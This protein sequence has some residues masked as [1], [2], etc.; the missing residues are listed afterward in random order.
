M[1]CISH[2]RSR[3]KRRFF[4]V[5]PS[6]ALVSLQL[7]PSQET[8]QEE[9]RLWLCCGDARSQEDFQQDQGPE[10]MMMLFRRRWLKAGTSKFR[11]VDKSLAYPEHSSCFR[12]SKSITGC[13]RL[14]MNTDEKAKDHGNTPWL[15]VLFPCHPDN[16][17]RCRLLIQSPLM[18]RHEWLK[19][20]H[21]SGSRPRSSICFAT[22]KVKG[23]HY[24]LNPPDS[25]KKNAKFDDWK[26]IFGGLYVSPWTFF[27]WEVCSRW[28]QLTLISSYFWVSFTDLF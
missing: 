24:P 11:Q 2:Y 1:Y 20:S 17:L 7:T 25:R 14:K 16:S 13:P 10:K 27:S 3:P 15:T 8:L 6:S 18:S 5:Q 19:N 4:F 22:A 23:I 28:R 9:V 26:V 12:P 21:G